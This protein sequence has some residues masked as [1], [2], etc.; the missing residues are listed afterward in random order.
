MCFTMFEF[1]TDGKKATSTTYIDDVY[2]ILEQEKRERFSKKMYRILASFCL[3]HCTVDHNKFDLLY[4]QGFDI[5]EI[6]KKRKEFRRRLKEITEKA[7]QKKKLKKL[8]GNQMNKL[9]ENIKE[10]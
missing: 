10:L 8:N 2:I 6:Q 4:Q 3:K 7:D 1:D 5:K 9:C